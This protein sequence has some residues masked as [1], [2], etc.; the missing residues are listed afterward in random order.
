MSAASN[1]A[2]LLAAA[3][4]ARFS[5]AGIKLVEVA[6]TSIAALRGT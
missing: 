4:V 2:A 3:F 6:L 5:G 1:A